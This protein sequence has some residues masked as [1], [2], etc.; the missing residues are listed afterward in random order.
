MQKK[1]KSM[2]DGVQRYRYT[3]KFSQYLY[4]LMSVYIVITTFFREY[5]LEK[6]LK[7]WT[8]SMD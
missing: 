2:I 8:G 3:I 5:M 4:T 6:I 7:A 1:E